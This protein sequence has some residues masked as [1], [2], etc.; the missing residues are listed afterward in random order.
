[1]SKFRIDALDKILHILED[2]KNLFKASMMGKFSA[3]SYVV[4]S[5]LKKVIDTPDLIIDVGANIGQ[6]ASSASVFFPNSQ[7]DAFEPI[8]KCYKALVK[9]TKGLKK[10]KTYNIAIGD[11]KK[12]IKFF[13][14]AE[15]Q[16]SSALK[17]TDFRLKIFPEAFAIDEIIVPQ[18][19]LDSL[20]GDKNI[21]ETC[22]LKIDVQGLEE[23]V[24][25]GS[26]KILDNIRYI[27]LEASVNSMYEGE[28]PLSK[29]LSFTESLGYKLESVV[30]SSRS[31]ITKNYI[32]FD[33]LF[34][35][36][37]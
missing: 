8:P 27:L 33:I 15:S 31:P 30:A 17:T 34:E 22:L 35:K 18:D 28:L 19:S 14:N 1:M 20:Y 2:P 29:M 23:K 21:P 11:T 10:I 4:C 36:V 9:N 3:A 7:I 6:F 12:N 5:R 24:L 16:S 25:K 32:E 37:N 13:I 26:E